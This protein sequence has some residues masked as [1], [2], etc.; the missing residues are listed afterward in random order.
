LSI[1]LSYPSLTDLLNNVP[2][3]P[4]DLAGPPLS[5]NDNA[6]GFTS[7]GSGGYKMILERDGGPGVLFLLSWPSLTDLLNDTNRTTV[8]LPLTLDPLFSLGGFDIQNSGTPPNRGSVPDSGSR[9]L[10]L[11][12]FA[13]LAIMSRV[14][15]RTASSNPK[16]R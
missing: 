3:G 9:V 13:G 2:S 12:A 6:A 5:I 10:P 8:T 11:I 15:R 4:F 7:D 16:G 14:F 1:F